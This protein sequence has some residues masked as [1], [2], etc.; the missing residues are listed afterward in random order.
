MSNRLRIV[1]TWIVLSFMG[2]MFMSACSTESGVSQNK[3]DTNWQLNQY[4]RV[5][6]IHVYTYSWERWIV[7]TIYDFRITKLSNTWAVWV[8]DG[9]GE[10][11][12]FCP[13]KGYGIPYSTS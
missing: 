1:I 3:D 7:Q 4:N 6:R 10:P 13:S 12:D 8:G 11:I 9:T 5:Q 2:I